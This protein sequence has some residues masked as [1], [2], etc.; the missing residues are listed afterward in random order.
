MDT[1]DRRYSTYHGPIELERDRHY[2]YTLHNPSIHL[3]E[4]KP[5]CIENK[6]YTNYPK[7]VPNVLAQEAWEIYLPSI[8]EWNGLLKCQR[9]QEQNE[10]EGVGGGEEK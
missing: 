4:S 1:K 9:S 10:Y 2:L 6:W 5:L 3:N 7:Y 8:V